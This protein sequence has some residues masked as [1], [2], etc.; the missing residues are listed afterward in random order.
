MKALSYEY[1]DNY[2]Y[3]MKINHISRE[4]DFPKRRVTIYTIARESGVSAATVSRILNNSFHGTDETRV[5]VQAIIE[6][7]RYQPSPAAKRT[8]NTRAGNRYVTKCSMFR[9]SK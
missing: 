8:M 3:S 5:R 9:A 7:H 6:K 4:S 2:I 1:F